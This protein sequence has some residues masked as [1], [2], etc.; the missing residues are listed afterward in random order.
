[1]SEGAIFSQCGKTLLLLTP[2]RKAQKGQA[3]PGVKELLRIP[4]QENS[5]L[6]VSQGYRMNSNPAWET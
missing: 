2:E 4:R 1:M 6:K 5:K 3:E